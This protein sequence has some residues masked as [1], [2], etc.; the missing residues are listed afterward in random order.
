MS[1]SVDKQAFR[2]GLKAFAGN[3]SVITAAHGRE[4]SGIVCTSVVSPSA[5]PPLLMAAINA[6]GHT[7]PLIR[8][9]GC[10]G[11]SSLGAGHEAVARAFSG[12]GGVEGEE[13]YAGA[14]WETAVTGARLLKGAAAGFD[15]VTQEIIDRDGWSI[16]IGRVV[17]V[18]NDPGAGGMIWWRGGFRA[19][20]A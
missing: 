14:E 20:D 19:L 8:D 12:F 11:W 7:L 15:C 16:V 1:E 13:R 4:A 5:E 6:G 10:F 17:A 3:I 2:E 18:R 9:A